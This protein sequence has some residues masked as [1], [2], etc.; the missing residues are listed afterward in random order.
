MSKFIII[1]KF[2]SK[3]NINVQYHAP[4]MII[5]AQDQGTAILIAE[6]SALSRFDEWSF[7]VATFFEKKRHAGIAPSKTADP[8]SKSQKGKQITGH[9][10]SRP[11]R[12]ALNRIRSKKNNQSGSHHEGGSMQMWS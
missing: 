2:Q 12:R 6:S 11:M 8:N 4:C 5:E 3:E 7:H 9:S 1:P 10:N